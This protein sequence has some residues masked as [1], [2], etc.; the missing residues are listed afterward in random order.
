MKYLP[1]DADL[2]IQNRRR[3][4]E[5]LKPSSIAVFNSNDIMPTSADGTHSFIQQ[6]DLFI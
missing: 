1:I 5:Q 2:F 6:T 4:I 3:F